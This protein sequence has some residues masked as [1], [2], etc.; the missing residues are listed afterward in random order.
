MLSNTNPETE[1]L[2]VSELPNY[3]TT[4]LPS[5]R[6]SMRLGPHPQPLSLAHCT[7]TRERTRVGDP[8]FALAR[9]AGA[10]T[11]LALPAV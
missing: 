5:H 8:A 9:A 11:G 3:R 1:L 6:F 10:A 2:A 7:P 4:E